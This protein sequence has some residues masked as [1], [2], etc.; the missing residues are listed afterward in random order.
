MLF[1]DIFFPLFSTPVLWCDN[2]RALVLPYNPM[3]H[4]RTKHI[5]IDYHFIRDKVINCDISI[6]FIS[7]PDQ[8]ADILTK[9]P[10]PALFR[11]YVTSSWYALPPFACGGML[12]IYQ[13]PL[14]SR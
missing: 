12:T 1:K 14:L 9:G 5:A 3:Y 11:F 6:K 7:T 8:I 10:N 4:A 2:I 13:Q